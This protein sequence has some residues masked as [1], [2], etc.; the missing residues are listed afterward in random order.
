[1]KRTEHWRIDAFEL[2]CW[3][4]LLRVP[5]TAKK[6][7]NPKGNQ[8]SIFIGRTDAEAETPIFWPP[9]AKSW[10]IGKELDAGKDWRQE[11]KGWDDWMASPPQWTWAWVSS[12]SWWWIRKPGMLQS[13]ALQRDQHDL[14]TELNWT[15]WEQRLINLIAS[16]WWLAAH[17]NTLLKWL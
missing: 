7:L 15:N 9:G 10:L 6:S 14:R 2:W 16:S 3:R 1:M 8:P 12:R 4:R 17:N 5:W 11:E 13:M